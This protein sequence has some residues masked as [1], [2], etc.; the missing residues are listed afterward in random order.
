MREERIVGRTGV[1]KEARP[2]LAPLCLIE[3]VRIDPSEQR[4]P[5]RALGS[6][7]GEQSDRD[8]F[9][10]IVAEEELIGALAG[11]HDLD[12]MLAGETREQEHGHRS[13]AHER[14]L[15]V[16]DD[17]RECGRDLP[18]RDVRNV[19]LAAER[20]RHLELPGALV[21]PRVLEAHGEGP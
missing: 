13:G 8:L 6:A 17:G 20:R 9:E 12:V 3:Q 1:E 5:R 16:T 7:Q 2:E 4:A 10:E 19:V 21:E 15:C 11:E 18:L 14:R